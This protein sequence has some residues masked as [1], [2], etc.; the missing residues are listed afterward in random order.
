M[1][2][3]IAVVRVR[4]KVRV[5]PNAKKSLE[6]LGLKN[7]NN[8]VILSDNPI[9]RGQIHAVKDFVTW[10]EIDETTM[11]ALKEKRGEEGKKIFRLHPPRK[12]WERKGIVH[13]YKN[14]GALGNRGAEINEL[15]KRML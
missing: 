5:N 1:S 13:I 3:N 2:K 15:L 14:G 4:G 7:V 11:N 6:T 12:G 10:G 9:N 8:C